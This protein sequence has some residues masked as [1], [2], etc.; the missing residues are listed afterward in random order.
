MDKFRHKLPKEELKKFTKEVSKKLVSSDYKNDRV[1]DPTLITEKQERKVKTYVKEFLDRAVQKYQEHEK[2]MV[3]RATKDKLKSPRPLVTNGHH[4]PM[5]IV[6][7]RDSGDIA[8]TDDEEAVATPGSADL[9]R[10]RGD[11]LIGS[12]DLTPSETP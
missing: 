10:K 7:N 4:A 12:P 1:D 5:E 9:K 2:K 8:M 6:V 11:E 3:E